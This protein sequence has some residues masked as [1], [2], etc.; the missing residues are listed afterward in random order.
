M[1]AHEGCGQRRRK[2]AVFLP[3]SAKRTIFAA[4]N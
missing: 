4:V 2:K 3:V 1:I